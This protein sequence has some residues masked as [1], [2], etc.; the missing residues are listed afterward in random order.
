MSGV[1]NRI[2]ERKKGLWWVGHGGFSDA[3]LQV[4]DIRET[5]GQLS[6]LLRVRVSNDI[7]PKDPF[8]RRRL[9]C[10]L[11]PPTSPL[12][13]SPDTPHSRISPA[14]DS[15]NLRL[16]QRQLAPPR[17]TS[18]KQQ[19]G[20][21]PPPDSSRSLSYIRTPHPYAQALFLNCHYMTHASLCL[22]MSR[23]TLLA[24][25]CTDISQG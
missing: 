7:I 1:E 19:R 10:L 14:P 15:R 12:P 17:N 20:N 24:F 13:C 18:A 4:E 21:T 9:L 6:Q 23:Y 16:T 25:P 8:A 3:G 2:E 22:K 5:I 11:R